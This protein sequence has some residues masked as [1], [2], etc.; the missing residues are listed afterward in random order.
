MTVQGELFG[1]IGRRPKARCARG[2]DAVAD[3]TGMFHRSPVG[4][5]REAAE[6][7]VRSGRLSAHYMIVLTEL[8]MFPGRTGAELERAIWMMLPFSSQEERAK[9]NVYEVRRRLS[10]LK[11][12]GLARQGAT[13]KCAVAKTSAVTWWP[14]EGA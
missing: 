8:R 7:M 6:R 5:E 3:V 14:G 11:K 13:R 2:E 1:D 12:L 10:D 9:I 4:G